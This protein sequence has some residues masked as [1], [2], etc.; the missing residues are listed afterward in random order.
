[1]S[2]DNK[3]ELVIFDL[4]GTT[5]KDEGIVPAVFSRTLSKHGISFHP[6]DLDALRGASKREVIRRFAASEA[7][8]DEVYREF[9]HKL[10]EQFSSM[11]V[12]EIEGTSN[13]FLQ[14]N[15]KGILI[16]LNTGF[17]RD[18]TELVLTR[19][20]WDRTWFRAIVCGDDVALGRPAPDMILRAMEICEVSDPAHVANV[21]DTVLDLQ[22]GWNAA[23]QFNIGVLSGA[24]TR[25]QLQLQPHTHL[26]P[27]IR[28]LPADLI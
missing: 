9:C 28:Q 6:K 17:D 16:A 5:V 24:H 10:A 20:G 3:V 25:E 21:G 26:I 18:I 22:A 23:V 7:K 4:A 19:V 14:L 15:E 8:S 11:G 13:T 2:T 1:M 12:H 27:S